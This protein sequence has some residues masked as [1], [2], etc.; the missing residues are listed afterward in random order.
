M[1]YPVL[2]SAIVW[3]AVLFGLRVSLSRWQP[4]VWADRT[5]TATAAILAVFSV[6]AV[7]LYSALHQLLSENSILWTVG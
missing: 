6:V 5:I 4:P 2:A 3:T 7:G 1:V